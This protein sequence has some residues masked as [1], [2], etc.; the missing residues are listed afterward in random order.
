M[1]KILFMV[2]ACC[3]VLQGYAQNIAVRGRVTDDTGGPLIGAAVKVKNGNTGTVTNTEGRFNLNA[4]GNATLIISYVGYEAKEVQ[5]STQELNISLARN[6]SSLGEVVV[7]GYGQQRQATLTGSIATIKGD[8]I[9]TT[10]NEN[11]LNMLT[12]KLPGVRVVQNSAEPGSFSNS[13]D[14][15]GLGAPLIIIDGVPRGNLN[16][17]DPNDIESISVLKDAAAAV[18]GVQAANG[19]ILVTTKKGKAGT[20]QL[21]YTVTV[22][23]QKPSGLP[24][25]LDATDWMTLF[26]ERALHNV[27]GGT[28]VYN[29]NDFDAYANGSKTSTDWYGAV[30]RNTAPQT[31][32]SLTASGGSEKMTYF[33]SLGYLSQQGFW[34]SGDLNYKKYNVRSN[35]T[36]KISSTL[37]AELQLS[38]ISDTRNQPY[39]DSWSIFKALWRHPPTYSLYADNNP[40]YINYL[41]DNGT[42][43][44]ALT[45]AA[46]DGYK[47][48]VSNTFQ[49]TFTL[50]YAVPFLEGLNAKALYSY[51]YATSD[52]KNFARSFNVYQAVKVGD[53]TVFNPKPLQTPSNVNRY[54]SA[55]PNTMLQFSLNYSHTFAKV[56]NVDVLAVYEERTQKSDNFSASRYLV[57]GTLDQ[58]GTG[59]TA[60]QIGTQDLGGLT[61]YAT[62]SYVGK[63][64]YD[65]NAKYLLDL[66]G[67]YDGSS[68]F[69]PT[70]QWGFF[71]AVSAGYR[72]SEESFIKDNPKLTFIDNIK[73]RASYGVMGDASGLRFQYLTGYDY[74]SSGNLQTLPGGSVFDGNYTNALGFRVLP[75]P[76]ITWFKSK[77]LNFGLDADFWKGLFGFQLDW[78]K[79]DRNGLLANRLLSLPGSLGAALPQENLN[80]DQS[81]GVE[82]LLTHRNR[83][84]QINYNISGNISYSRTKWKHYERA[85]AGNSYDNWRN[86]VND[87]YNDVWWGYTGAGRFES[88]NDIYNY[89]VDNG[90]GNRATLP[91]DYKYED[92][93]NDGYI[94]D[95]DRHPIASTYN[96]NTDRGTST[97]NP[98]LINFGVSI[99]V[100]YRGF[101]LSALIQGAAMKWIAYPEALA[102]PL[103]FN[104]N[105]LEQYMDRWH[106]ADP[107][108]DPYDPN[109]QYVPGYFAMTG[110]GFD[111]NSSF[112]VKN[113]AYAR[114]KSV[115]LG[116]TYVFSKNVTRKAGLRQARLY[117]NG[118]NIFTA[119]GIR[120]VDPEHPS[121]LYGYVYPLNKTYNV[122]LSVDF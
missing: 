90:G 49:G 105:A 70:G 58:L 12:G 11:V 8:E 42:S 66:S 36:A 72:I 92:W 22:G 71:P 25:V 79:R 83:I 62:K 48:S 7:V 50:N 9:K 114:L 89:N 51:D 39:E 78:F 93:N 38:G 94:D 74:P 97:P 118:Y 101:D 47:K 120:Y 76:D 4:P 55:A 26:N 45:N 67:R 46:I 44:L 15:R 121:D 54:Y 80:S 87:R 63:L 69:A 3:A 84:G 88:F 35:L 52:N 5:A 109:T 116:Y 59:T 31:E 75:N 119:T 20:T 103:N 41:D 43:A 10:R 27:N 64:H 34:K 110:T 115:E 18:Y 73:F 21:N 23:M 53:S 122:G 19:V 77:T 113:A 86:N 107:A 104:G 112:A 99:G 117:V 28:P 33:V 57:L 16:R 14:I 6:N 37:T 30:V 106:T 91:G 95:L 100:S 85:V 102:T 108:A 65:Y 24:K 111:G 17:L 32:H 68:R 81:S 82:L 29:Q 2:L 1:K 40:D 61:N 13:F 60:N 56:H 96:G 98:P